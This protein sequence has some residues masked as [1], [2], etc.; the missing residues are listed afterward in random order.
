[1]RRPAAAALLLVVVAPHAAAAHTAEA[2][3]AGWLARTPLV[4]ALVL[5]VVLYAR[6]RR[7]LGA[8]WPVRRTAAAAAGAAAVV[9]ALLTPLD[10][11]AA[12]SVTAHM[13]QHTILILA[14][15]PLLALGRPLTVVGAG[16]PRAPRLG[17][18]LGTP[19]P[20]LACATHGVALWL[21]HLPPSYDAALAH[22]LLHA[23]AH[24]TLLGSAV[25]LWWS[26]SRGRARITGALWLFVTGFHAGG[27]GALLALSTKPWFR[28]ATLEDQQLAGLIMWVPAG[29]VLTS[30]ALALLAGWLRSGSPRPSA[31]RLGAIVATFLSV[32]T[33]AA[34]N[35]AS[36]TANAMTG[37]EA[38]RG[39]DAIRRYGC[40]TC[41]T[42]PGVPGAVGS[43]GP[44]L[45][46]VARRSYVAGSPN[47][48]EHLVAWLQHPRR[49]RPGTP[50]PEMGV[51]ERDARDIAAY[52]YTLK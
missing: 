48:P 10:T 13:I 27:L 37:G 33:L 32:A 30:I 9:V 22:P 51:T 38:T 44:P 49:V 18:V 25:F 19:R 46:Q 34:C 40:A 8:G 45:A 15:A 52:L 14:A 16:L 12:T 28:G 39:P 20:G 4:L 26:V 47:A 7:R 41:H 21:W 3:A 29:A 5:A 17:R 11:A 2:A 43:I 23:L 36:R 31:L 35:A 24:A 50:M 6:G 42:I 1:M